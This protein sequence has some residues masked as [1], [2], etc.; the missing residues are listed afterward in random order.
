MKKKVN[1]LN[2]TDKLIIYRNI[3]ITINKEEGQDIVTGYFIMPTPEEN[4]GSVIRNPHWC[5]IE[6]IED[7]PIRYYADVNSN[8]IICKRKWREIIKN[9]VL[10]TMHCTFAAINIKTS[11]EKNISPKDVWDKH[12]EYLGNIDILGEK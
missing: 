2:I 6:T 8:G 10:D 4:G 3:N 1:I 9:G 5:I 7:L 12:N 11:E